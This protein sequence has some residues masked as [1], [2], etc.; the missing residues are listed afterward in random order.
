MFRVL[1]PVDGSDNA[2]R[3]LERAVALVRDR[4]PFELHLLN[5]QPSLSGDVTTFVGSATVRDYHREEGEKALASART[6]LDRQG[7][8]YTQHVT[9]G[10]VGESIAGFAKK[11]GCETI[12]MGTRGMGKIAGALLGSVS[13]EVIRHS[14]VPVTLVK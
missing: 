5:V 8:P 9:V 4:K 12:I 2:V 14:D 6:M 3:A 7:I 1:V 10:P 13:T 11:L